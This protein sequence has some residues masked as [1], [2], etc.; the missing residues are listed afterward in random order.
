MAID[1]KQDIQSVRIPFVGN[2]LTRISNEGGLYFI[3]ETDQYFQNGLFW[4]IDNPVIKR[5][6]SILHRGRD[7]PA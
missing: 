7:I 2:Y 4:N 3:E 1:P 5:R 6:Q